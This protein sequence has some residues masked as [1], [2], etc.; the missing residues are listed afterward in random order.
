MNVSITR[1]TTEESD[2][3][4]EMVKEL[5]CEITEATEEPH[6]NVDV[7]ILQTQARSLL[8]N[9]SY[10]VLLASNV[11][12]FA[13]LGFVALFEGAA[14]Y[15]EGVFGVVPELYVR[16]AFRSQGIG[17]MLL[18]HAA[19]YGKSQGWNR[20]EVTT[21]PLPHFARTLAFYEKHGFSIAGGKK[22]KRGIHP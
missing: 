15:T 9:G 10:V 5:L 8:L 4:A 13:S 12:D 21:P 11:E 18:D 2:L 16:P 7:S 6:F 17:A 20:L 22:L 19:A 1:A 14:L 3:V